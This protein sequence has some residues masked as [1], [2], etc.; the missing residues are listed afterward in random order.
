VPQGTLSRTARVFLV[1]PGLSWLDHTRRQP[2]IPITGPAQPGPA[3]L[4][5]LRPRAAIVPAGAWP[6]GARRTG[7]R[8]AGEKPP[9][10]SGF[11]P[12]PRISCAVSPAATPRVRVVRLACGY[13]PEMDGPRPASEPAPSPAAGTATESAAVGRTHEWFGRLG[14]TEP[15]PRAALGVAERIELVWPVTVV[16][17]SMDTRGSLPGPAMPFGHPWPLET[18]RVSQELRSPHPVHEMRQAVWPRPCI[19]RSTEHIVTLPINNRPVGVCHATSDDIEGTRSPRVA[20]PV[21][22]FP[23]P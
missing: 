14:D 7:R 19:I 21:S 22:S 8:R 1:Q 3:A 18:L 15:S 5:R 20:G 17:F 10:R 6:V 23:G 2:G 16:A 11:T 13:F 12:A 4:A 9:N